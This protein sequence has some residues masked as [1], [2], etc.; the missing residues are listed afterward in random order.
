MKQK[1][2]QMDF[3]YQERRWILEVCESQQAI[4][5]EWKV[6]LNNL[7]PNV[8][9]SERNTWMGILWFPVLNSQQLNSVFTSNQTLILLYVLLFSS[10]LSS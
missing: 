10:F 3:Y 8:V 7:F 2:K 1:S 5:W 9:S 6:P 4:D